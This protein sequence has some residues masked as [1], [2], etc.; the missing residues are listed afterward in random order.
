MGVRHFINLDTPTL[1]YVTSAIALIVVSAAWF[2]PGKS[3]DIP[4]YGLDENDKDAPK[5]RWMRD[6]INL[7]REG[8]RKVIY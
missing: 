1:Y 2:I 5:K 3:L 8:Y 6:S 7:L 4:F